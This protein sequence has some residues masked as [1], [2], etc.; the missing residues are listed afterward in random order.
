MHVKT[1]TLMAASVPSSRFLPDVT[2]DVPRLFIAG[3]FRLSKSDF[4]FILN[5]GLRYLKDL[6]REI[7]DRTGGGRGRSNEVGYAAA[8]TLR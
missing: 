4:T 3:T 6:V 1:A 7:F 8:S 2:L 5:D